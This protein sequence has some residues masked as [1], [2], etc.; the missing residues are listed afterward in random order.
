MNVP[1]FYTTS[2]LGEKRKLTPEGFLV[3][4]DVAMARTGE[5][6]YGPNETPVQSADGV[7]GVRISRD[8]GDVFAEDTILS[9]I[10]K[11]VTDDHPEESLTTGNYRQHEV[12][13]VMNARRGEGP[14]GDLLLGDIIVKDPLTIQKILDGKIEVSAGYDADYEELSPGVGRQKNIYYNHLALVDKGR[15]GP[16]C[17]IGDY[18]PPE[19]VQ[20][21]VDMK[22]TKNIIKDKQTLTARLTGLFRSGKVTDADIEKIMEEETK[23]DV[24]LSEGEAGMG[25][26]HIHLGG[27][28]SGEKP[29]KD[30]LIETDPTS[31]NTE[32]AAAEVPPAV[33]A[34]LQGLETGMKQIVAALQKIMPAEEEQAEA[35]E[36]MEEAPENVDEKTVVAAKDSAF[37]Q[38]SFKNTVAM[39]EIIEPG[40][41][42]PTFDAASAP[43]KTLDA[44]CGFRRKVLDLAYG[45]AQNR[46]V[47]DDLNGGKTVDTKCMA[48]DK[49][50][51]MFRGL[52]IARRDMNN[53][54]ARDTALPGHGGAV[55]GTSPIKSIADLNAHNKAKREARAKA[56]S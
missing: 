34:R 37:M 56:A 48:C 53:R 42:L 4:Y 7:S 47:M 38:D 16:R 26:V 6:L 1:R 44:L 3:C 10:G 15:C 12:G 21:N 46:D 13:T 30:D 28:P 25:E 33:E 14:M 54:G 43:K 17:A 52:A 41:R 9:I 2:A 50:R 49:V 18:Q 19:L 51:N 39:A 32:P 29:V 31:A 36:L 45:K 23:D 35:E 27:A 20:E 55:R 8:E 11:P 40:V 5:M 24:T 22:R